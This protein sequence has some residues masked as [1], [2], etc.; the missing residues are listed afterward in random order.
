MAELLILLELQ[1]DGG[2][3]TAIVHPGE[4]VQVSL[5]TPVAQGGHTFT[6]VE[7]VVDHAPA[8]RAA[9]VRSRT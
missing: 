8:P 6:A 9:E 4:P 1:P 2:V 3:I 5:P 7:V